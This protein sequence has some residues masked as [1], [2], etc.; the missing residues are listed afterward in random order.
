MKPTTISDVLSWQVWKTRLRLCEISN[1]CPLPTDGPA[2]ASLDRVR[3]LMDKARLDQRM[4][5]AIYKR[6][7]ERSEEIK[8]GIISNR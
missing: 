5:D 4:S 2:K 3:L 8:N 6:F 7:A 1:R